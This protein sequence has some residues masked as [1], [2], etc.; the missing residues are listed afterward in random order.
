MKTTE[1]EKRLLIP[2]D[3]FEEE[4]S[5]GLGRLNREEAEEDLRELRSRID[6][7][8]RKPRIV[9]IPAAAAVVI[10][11]LASVLYISIFREPGAV[12]PEIAFSA[13]EIKDTA[14]IAMA[15]PLKRTELQSPS[16]VETLNLN[17]SPAIKEQ[18]PSYEAMAAEL[19]ED[20]N[21]D[22][23]VKAEEKD[24]VVV[25]AIPEAARAVQGVAAAQS[26][27]KSRAIVVATPNLGVATTS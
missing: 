13:A 25:E 12:T 22:V 10:I 9:W 27:K 16:P 23:E 8:L 7:R 14:M 3:D 11:L 26:D 1:T 24:E 17:V 2:R 18:A 5:E 4:A 6:R 20:I 21:P 19:A 15:E